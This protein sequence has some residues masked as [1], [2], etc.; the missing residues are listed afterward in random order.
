M[1]NPYPGRLDCRGGNSKKFPE[2]MKYFNLPASNYEILCKIIC[3]CAP[4]RDRLVIAEIA[5]KCQYDPA[6]ILGNM[7]FLTSVGIVVGGMSKSLTTVGKSLASA[8]R[9]NDIEN[10]RECWH[11]I[12]SEC[13]PIKSIAT[14][15]EPHKPI[16]KE[17]VM[18]RIAL[19]LGVTL[20]SQNDAR[21]TQLLDIFKKIQ[22][23]RESVDGYVFLSFEQ[24]IVK[25]Y[26]NV[27][28][29]S[30]RDDQSAPTAVSSNRSNFFDTN[31]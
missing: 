22:L 28:P 5:E 7:G 11:Q 25:F 14:Q 29:L 18:H 8:I 19:A 15:L 12:F 4:F 6:V 27:I 20:D 31:P 10:I 24:R 2:K 13:A 9:V 17:I 26:S 30:E 21:M 1:T 3:E 16:S 23:M